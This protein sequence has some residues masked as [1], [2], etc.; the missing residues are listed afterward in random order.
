MIKNLFFS[1][2]FTLLTISALAPVSAQVDPA[3]FEAPE[4]KENASYAQNFN[5]G[6]YDSKILNDCI[7]DLIDYARHQYYYLEPLK[8]HYLFDSVAGMQATYQALKNL[9]TDENLAP[10][11][12]TFY[13]LKKYGLSYRGIELVTRAKAFSGTKEYSYYDLSMELITPLLKNAKLSAQLLDKQ[14]TYVGIAVEADELMRTMYASIILGNDRTFQEYKSNPFDKRSV[15]TKG[16][17]GL[18]YYDEAICRKCVNDYSLELLSSMISVDSEG[19]VYLEYS[20]A[21]ALKKMIGRDGD[22]I[23]LDFILM[24]QYDCNDMMID[25]DKIF[26]GTVTKPIFYDKIIKANEIA[27]KSNRIK[28]LIAKVPESIDL[29]EDFFINILVLKNKKVVCKTVYKKGVIAHNVKSS[30]K[31]NFLVD[32]ITIINPGEWVPVSEKDVIEVVIPYNAAN[33]SGYTLAELEA[34]VEE[35]SKEYPAYEVNKI[36]IISSPSIDQLSNQTVLRN[37]QKNAESI[38]KVLKTKYPEVQFTTSIGD[39]WEKFKAEISNEQN[40]YYYLALMTKEEVIRS[41]RERNN[42]LAKELEEDYLSKQRYTKIVMHINYLIDGGNEQEFVL[43]K[44]NQA[45]SEN[46]LPM[47]V[48]VQKYIIR[49]IEYQRYRNFPADRLIIPETKQNVPLLT[50]QLYMNYYPLDKPTEEITNKAQTILN[51]DPK[52][53][54]STFN[55]CVATALVQVPENTT[56]IT[57]KQSDIDKL[58]TLDAVPKERI[59]N[60]NIEFQVLVLEYLKNAPQNSEHTNLRTNTFAKIKEIRNPVMDS[61]E[62]AYKLAK[63]FIDGGDYDYAID[64]MTPFIDNSRVSDDFIFAYVSLTGHKEEYFM[65]SL[66]TKAVRIAKERDARFLCVVL[67]KLTPCIYDNVEVRKMAC[68]F[69]K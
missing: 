18:E 46:N 30:D 65:S 6:N 20:D 22:A 1:F 35:K 31:V 56:E 42:E 51:L 62:A 55:H 14:Y 40:D 16:K 33:K 38:A 12:T 24:S 53:P 52:N 3:D 37:M 17:G 5:P 54:I 32:D 15:I 25:N 7:S 50:N 59:N 10:Y 36:D 28:S 27:D 13:R 19:D 60:L 41:L 9:K 45:V 63:I 58:Y 69:C 34:F 64:I 29:S 39:S 2:I 21:K 61:W 66:F 68:D 47:A 67:D 49:Q 44:F 8:H 43:Y 11:K 26:R 48:A 57:K 4:L 23:A